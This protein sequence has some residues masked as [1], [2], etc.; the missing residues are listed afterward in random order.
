VEKNMKKIHILT[1]VVF[2]CT[3][4]F[5][6]AC[7]S[8]YP[9]GSIGT[10][11]S[12]NLFYEGDTPLNENS[13]IAVIA[14]ADTPLESYPHASLVILAPE[15]T[16]EGVPFALNHL[17]PASYMIVGIL[18]NTS[19]DLEITPVAVGFTTVTV[20]EDTEEISDIVIELL[21]GLVPPQ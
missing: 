13:S 15:F 21:E 17:A 8:E 4:L 5:I 11:I 3:I 6:G 18:A 2:S 7:G 19:E 10:R 1:I 12:G 20:D 9:E 14:Y 16:Q